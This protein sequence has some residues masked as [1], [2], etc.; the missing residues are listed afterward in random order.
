[1]SRPDLPARHPAVAH[2]GLRDAPEAGGAGLPHHH[3]ELA[4]QDVEGGLDAGLSERGEA[5]DVGA[6]HAHGRRAEGQRL[7]DVG[8]AA[9]APVDDD[10]G[11]PGHARRHSGTHSTDERRLFSMRPPWFET[12][13]PSAPYSSARSASS[14]VTMPLSTTFMEVA[15]LTA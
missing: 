3:P 1:M 14:R 5:E 12:Q 10:R 2:V 11:A 15:S 4:V 7:E 9:E 13:M 8:A 6:P